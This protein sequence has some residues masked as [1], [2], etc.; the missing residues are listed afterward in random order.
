M[1]TI[2]KYRNLPF[3]EY[4]A[5]FYK[6]LLM[7]TSQRQRGLELK[8][9]LVKHENIRILHSNVEAFVC[10]NADAM[11]IIDLAQDE[12]Q[13][14][15]TL[16]LMI[17]CLFEVVQFGDKVVKILSM[18]FSICHDPR[19]LKRARM[20][21][22]SLPWIFHNLL[23]SIFEASCP[24]MEFHQLLFD[25]RSI[26]GQ[27]LWDDIGR[28]ACLAEVSGIQRN[29]KQ[30][31]R[32]LGFSRLVSCRDAIPYLTSQAVNAGFKSTGGTSFGMRS[33]Q[34]SWNTESRALDPGLAL[35]LL[36]LMSQKAPWKVT[37]FENKY[38]QPGSLIIPEGYPATKC[39]YIDIRE[40]E[41]VRFVAMLQ[42]TGII[43]EVSSNVEPSMISWVLGWANREASQRRSANELLTD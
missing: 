43:V 3:P 39:L 36:G 34:D 31:T 2:D 22:R 9:V 1:D 18:V 6:P 25:L 15:W 27:R 33:I 8:L 24:E 32:E 40:K 16:T 21:R 14:V 37:L 13:T 38:D 7:Q 11:S 29:L 42:S 35:V 10:N 28:L 12:D 5:I 19:C 26:P 4:S 30:L 23:I 20:Q 41:L 17:A